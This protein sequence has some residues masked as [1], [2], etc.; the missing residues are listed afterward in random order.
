MRTY[1][2]YS[3]LIDCEVGDKV[4]VYS[5]EVLERNK[6]INLSMIGTIE[7]IEQDST[8]DW[9]GMDYL[10]YLVQIKLNNG[11]VVTIRDEDAEPRNR[12][13]EFI[14]LK[15]LSKIYKITIE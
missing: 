3:G 14:T 9:M 8:P 2:T 10:S 15:D 7:Y 4:Y 13:F 6:N 12:P 1:S 11:L 5:G